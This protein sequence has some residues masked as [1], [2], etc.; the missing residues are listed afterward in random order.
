MVKGHTYKEVAT[1]YVETCCNCGVL[2]G[3]PRTLNNSLRE[4]QRTFYCPNGHPQLYTKSTA[5]KL[6]DRL[7]EQD[8]DFKEKQRWAEENLTIAYRRVG[9]E[10]KKRKDAEKIIKR[11]HKGVCP[12]CDRTFSNLA[13]HMKTKHPEVVGATHK[14]P[15]MEKINKKS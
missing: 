7:D 3:M 6:K 13:N 10:T 1:M 2:F 12:C 4:T 9:E 5:D 11:I 14:M 8:R 15:A